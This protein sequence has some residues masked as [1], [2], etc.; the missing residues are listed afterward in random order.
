MYEHH[1]YNA[2]DFDF[3]FQMNLQTQYIFF[4]F[5]PLRWDIPPLVGQP[6][7]IDFRCFVE[8]FNQLFFVCFEHQYNTMRAF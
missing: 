5:V 7:E 1:I 2:L 4:I 3:G 8:W 6:Q